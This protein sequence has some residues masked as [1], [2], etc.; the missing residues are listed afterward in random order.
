[1]MGAV[2]QATTMATKIS[3][4]GQKLLDYA[5]VHSLNQSQLATKIGMQQGILNQIIT[6]KN[7]LSVEKALDIEEGTGLPAEGLLTL[8]MELELAQERQERDKVLSA[9]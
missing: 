5:E 7:R 1:M 3:A 6:G 4:V 2:L 8:Q 9:G